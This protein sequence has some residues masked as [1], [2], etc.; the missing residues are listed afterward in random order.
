MK[1]MFAMCLADVDLSYFDVSKV[2][3]MEG[4]FL[5]Y[6]SAEKQITNLVSWYIGNLLKPNSGSSDFASLAASSIDEAVDTSLSEFASGITQSTATVDEY[7]KTL[8]GTFD[9]LD[10]ASKV[11][12]QDNEFGFNANEINANNPSGLTNILSD[13]GLTSEAYSNEYLGQFNNDASI[14][15]AQLKTALVST[16]SESAD[17]DKLMEILN[18]AAANP[19]QGESNF[20]T[21]V[22]KLTLPDS[23][24]PAV[25]DSTDKTCSMKE[26]FALFNAFNSAGA[27]KVEDVQELVPN[28]AGFNTINVTDMSYMFFG[29]M[30][31]PDLIFN[32]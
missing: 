22:C 18:N 25:D 24:N 7:T 1:Y 29:F 20:R 3:N 5:A 26:M 27:K 8:N 17:E 2:T 14:H 6:G 23:F 19:V 9:F 10:A 13:A 15:K 32:D 28:F 16:L 30:I 21:E 4:M 31:C 12:V 11:N